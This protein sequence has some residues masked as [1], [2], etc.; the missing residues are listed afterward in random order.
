MKQ[1]LADVCRSHKLD[2]HGNAYESQSEHIYKTS[3]RS[4]VEKMS[5]KSIFNVHT[6]LACLPATMLRVNPQL[7]ETKFGTCA[8]QQGASV[9]VGQHLVED[10]S[11]SSCPGAEQATPAPQQTTVPKLMRSM[12]LK[13]PPSSPRANRSE[14]QKAV[15][16]SRSGANHLAQRS[17]PTTRRAR[18]TR[19]TLTMLNRRAASVG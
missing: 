18:R 19:M 13:T 12:S 16:P 2:V 10:A 6:V 17:C 9:H 15:R 7:N 8:Q 4:S 11:W 1:E 3:A 5:I 14:L